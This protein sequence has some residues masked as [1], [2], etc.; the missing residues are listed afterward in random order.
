VS[1]RKN[2]LI[3]FVYSDRSHSLGIVVGRQRYIDRL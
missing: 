3:I 2:T 1:Y